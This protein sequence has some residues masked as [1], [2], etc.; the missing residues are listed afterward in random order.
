MDKFAT[1]GHIAGPPPVID[2]FQICCCNFASSK[3]VF[4]YSEDFLTPL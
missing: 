2:F 3:K 4:I 1:D